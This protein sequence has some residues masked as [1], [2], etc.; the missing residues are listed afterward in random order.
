MASQYANCQF[1]EESAGV[2]WFCQSCD[3]NLCDVCNTK[4]HTKIHTKIEKLSEHKVIPFKHGGNIDDSENERKVDLKEIACSN[5]I[6]EKCITYCLNC[7]KSLCS[8]CVVRQFQYVELNKLY[9]DKHLSLKDLKSKIDECYPFFEEKATLFRKMDDCEVIKHNEI[10]EKICNRKNEAKDVITKEAS[11]LVEV[12]EG[13]WDP[14]NNPVVSE[15]KR[16]SLIEQE[17]LTRKNMLDEVLETQDPASVFLTVEKISCEM[18]Q[19]SALEIKPQ[20]LI[21]LEPTEISLKEVLGSVIRIPKLI[22]IRTFEVD[23]PEINGLVSLNDDICVIYNSNSRRFV[24]F[25]ISGLKF[26]ITND[27]IDVSLES[28]YSAYAKILD[29]TNYHGDILLTDDKFQLRQLK[30]NGQFE[31]LSSSITNDYLQFNGIHATDNDEIILGFTNNSRSSAGI[32]EL[33]HM[34]LNMSYTQDTSIMRRVEGSSKALFTLPKKITKNI[35]DYMC[36]IDQPMDSDNGRVVVIGKFGEPKWIY[37][38]HPDINSENAFSPNDILTTSSGLVLVAERKTNAIH[39]LSKD[40]QFICNCIAD[41]EITE[42]VSICLNKK[43]Q[44]M[45]GC[46]DSEKTKLQIANFIE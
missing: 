44:L 3:L 33:T 6:S 20:E 15:R 12:M 1:C 25:T 19:K 2:K 41:S 16:L 27:I 18:P 31:N 30:K 39:V 28:T 24:F 23:F 36:V 17:L 37:R 7:D 10:K 21:L 4:I 11:N 35:N 42:P 45:I 46:M 8:S 9:E 38:G 13:I 5:H 29:I 22:L 14:E 32:I 26:V 40:G 43:G 34:K